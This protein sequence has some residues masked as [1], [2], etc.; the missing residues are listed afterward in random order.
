M[1]EEERENFEALCDRIA[2]KVV[3]KMVNLQSLADW[4]DAMNIA[5]NNKDEDDLEMTEE[6]RTVGELARLMTIMN[7]F[8]DRE[9]Y[10]KCAVVNKMIKRLNKKLENE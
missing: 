8:Q 3:V 7:M 9:E 1:T 4:N 2:N 10:E 5:K 6:D